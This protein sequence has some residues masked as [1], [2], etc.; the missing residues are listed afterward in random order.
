M[1]SLAGWCCTVGD[2][3]S[4][5]FSLQPLQVRAA[6]HRVPFYVKLKGSGDVCYVGRGQGL[7]TI[8]QEVKFV[9]PNQITK[10]LNI[11]G[12]LASSLQVDQI[13]KLCRVQ[14]SQWVVV[15]V[16]CF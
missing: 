10:Q 6:P 13:G 5:F 4:C 1:G 3:T 8:P 9:Q 12:G 7:E 2:G 11:Q 16:E 14:G 15:E